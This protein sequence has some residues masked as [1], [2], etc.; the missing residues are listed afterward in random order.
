MGL[1][2]TYRGETSRSSR[3]RHK[4]HLDDLT[5]GLTSS[6]LVAHVI[7]AQGGR[8]PTF[9]FA[10]STVEPRPLH[11]AI[12]ESVE[13]SMLPVGIE[14]MNHCQEWGAPRVPILTAQGGDLTVKGLPP[15]LNERVEWSRTTFE[16][17]R[18]GRMKRVRLV[19]MDVVVAPDVVDTTVDVVG[20][21]QD[22]ELNQVCDESRRKRARKSSPAKMKPGCKSTKVLKLKEKDQPKITSFTF[23]FGATD[24]REKQQRMKQVSQPQMPPPTPPPLSKAP[25]LALLPPWLPPEMLQ[26]P[27]VLTLVQQA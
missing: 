18:D 9:L 10:I 19:P 17:I 21:V 25:L 3:Q 4:E 1:V 11:R 24:I 13:I 7:E 26:S 12:R 5:S 27:D 20:R 23:K 14:N 2:T 8:M 22:K 16:E 15:G 6:P